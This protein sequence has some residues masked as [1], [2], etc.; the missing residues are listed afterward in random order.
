MEKM[1][2]LSSDKQTQALIHL[3]ILWHSLITVL[4]LGVAVTLLVGILL[5]QTPFWL[6]AI[7]SIVLFA[8]SI[9]SGLAALNLNR[10]RRQGRTLSLVVNYLGFLGCL[11]YGLHV[12][13][14]FS[15]IDVLAA[16]FGRGLI[17]LAGVLVGYLISA[18]GDRFHHQVEIEERFRK[19]GR[20]VAWISTVIFFIVILTPNLPTFIFTSFSKPLPL[21]LMGGV[22]LF[23]FFIRA[24]WRNETANALQAT[25]A[26]VETLDGYLFLSPNFLGFILFFAGPLLFSFYISFTNWDAFGNAQWVGFENYARIFT[27]DL[28]P[29][30]YPDQVFT[31]VLDYSRFDEVTRFNL[32]GQWYILGALDKLF[33]IALGN[34]IFF[35]IVAVPLSVIPALLISNILNSRMPGMRIFRAI[36]FI[37]SI[38]ATVGVALI[39]QWLYNASVGYINYGITT[40]VNLINTVFNAGLAD[41][42]IHWL[43]DQRTAL[44]SIILMSA[45]Q[46]MGFNTVLFLAGLQNI[47]KELYEA[48]TVD[49]AG[50]WHRFWDLTLPLLA[51]TTFFVITTTTI[52]ALQV[53]EQVFVMTNPI[54][55]PNN[56]TMTLVLYLYQSGFQSFRQ[57]YASAIAWVLF[58]IIFGVTLLQF[59]RQR[60]TSA[61]QV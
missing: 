28:K 35:C 52:Q 4:G 61:Y 20:W 39:W 10:K 15:G 33:W 56:S 22:F 49:G 32:F 47:P 30:Q 11:F 1:K 51:P 34:T 55:G 31:E 12:L 38:A 54:G 27:L 26:H 46:T 19:I 2:R 43:S 59:Q 16:N 57:G 21:A 3:T 58:I 41:P 50:R 48:A 5:S 23:G 44:F 45:W 18:T 42:N 7:I 29:L 13:G 9:T 37:P 24:I 8:T 17:P 40:S 60:H 53:F 6:R 25:Q 36:Y 14:I